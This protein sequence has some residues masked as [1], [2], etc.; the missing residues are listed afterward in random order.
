MQRLQAMGERSGGKGNG[1]G[2]SKGERCEIAGSVFMHILTDAALQKWRAHFKR[3]ILLLNALHPREQ[4]LDA[5]EHVTDHQAG[6]RESDTGAS[7]V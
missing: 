5:A 7:P 2:K 4:L 1:W 6:G 3:S